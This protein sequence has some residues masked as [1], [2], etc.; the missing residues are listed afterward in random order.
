MANKPL[1]VFIDEG[2]DFN[3][4][5][6][7][8]KHYTITCVI[9]HSPW[10]KAEEI[11]AKHKLILSREELSDLGQGYLEEKLCH[12]FHACEDRQ[13]VRDEFFE[14]IGQMK[15]LKAHSIV[16]RKNRTNP[17]IREPERFYPKIMSYLLK[18]VF[19]TYV[20]SSLCIFVDNLP[21]NKRK[22]AFLSALKKEIAKNR[23]NKKDYSI[24]F[25]KS[26]SIKFLQVA[27]YINWAILRKWERSDLRSYELIKKFL[28]RKEL[29]IYRNGDT[30]YYSF[31]Q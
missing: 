21:V 9:T 14:I 17:S 22:R 12:G 18:Y 24:F 20:S 25:P 11:T 3:F 1:Y 8:S 23:P 27:D 2:G 10:E 28:G 4:S 30:E 6:S 7:G 13:P 16:V 19:K 26:G 5:P 31:K 29:D 15:Y